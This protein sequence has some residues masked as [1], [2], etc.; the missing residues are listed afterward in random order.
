MSEYYTKNAPSTRKGTAVNEKGSRSAKWQHRKAK[1]E[2]AK[3]RAEN[4]NALSAEKQLAAL[5]ARLGKGNGAKRE[6]KRLSL[7]NP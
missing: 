5:D 3:E 7:S 2:A 1:L 4:R 6:R